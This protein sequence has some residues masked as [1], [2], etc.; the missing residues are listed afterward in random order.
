MEKSVWDETNFYGVID[1]LDDKYEENEKEALRSNLTD[2]FGNA[3]SSTFFGNKDFFTNFINNI[4]ENELK[5]YVENTI[6][7]SMGKQYDPKYVIV[8]RRAV[9]SYDAKPENFWSSDPHIPLQ[10]LHAEVAKETRLHTVI[11]V[12]S[13]KKLQEHGIVDTSNGGK[14]DG[15]IA[16]DPNK[17]FSDFLFMYKPPHEF[18]ELVEYLENGGKKREDVLSMLKDSAIARAVNQ[19]L[20]IKDENGKFITL[21]DIERGTQEQTISA[22]N[23]ETRYLRE[24]EISIKK[25]DWS[26]EDEW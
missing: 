14:S 7:H 4:P 16:I 26:K 5:M 13:L 20:P 17:N 23:T 15:E 10:G 24:R 1:D 6:N 3:I 18:F 9:P 12:T 21:A 22:I 11:M 25:S 8:A 19:G 2:R